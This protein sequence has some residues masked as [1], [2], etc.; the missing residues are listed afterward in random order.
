MIVAVFPGQQGLGRGSKTGKR[1]ATPKF[2]SIDTM[3]PFN[4]P[5]LLRAPGFNVAQPHPHLLDRER[6]GERELSAVV[7]LQFTDGKRER[8]AEGREERVAG[9][10]IFLWIQSEDPV[11]GAVINGGV[12]ETLGS[13]HFDFFDVHLHT[14]PWTLSTEQRQLTRAP[15]GLPAERRVSE[16][17]ANAANRRGGNPDP[18]HAVEPDAGAD[19]PEVEVAPGLFNQ[20]H[21]RIRNPACSD[22]GIARDQAR[23]AV[24][25][26]A[27]PP[28]SDRLPIPSQTA[29]RLL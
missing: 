25:L 8:D 29:G 17:V 16:A 12:L 26:P 22:R 13:G 4:F 14:I 20:R 5:V 15:L 2:L 9:P 23:E 10:L 7:D 18:M 19:R 24:D 11:A 27:T 21:G 28:G 1:R 3:T 6:E